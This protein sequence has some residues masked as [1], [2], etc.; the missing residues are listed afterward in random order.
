MKALVSGGRMTPQPLQIQNHLDLLREALLSADNPEFLQLIR[1]KAEDILRELEQSEQDPLEGRLEDVDPAWMAQ[2]YEA[3]SR[4]E[5]FLGDDRKLIDRLFLARQN[6]EK[7]IGL[8]F[9]QALIIN[10][11][12]D[13]LSWKGIDPPRSEASAA[14]R[15]ELCESP[16]VAASPYAK[17]YLVPFGMTPLTVFY[18]TEAIG[19]LAE[20]LIR[21]GGL[22]TGQ[23]IALSA[24]NG[25]H[26]GYQQ[27]EFTMT[28]SEVGMT[29]GLPDSQSAALTKWCIRVAQFKQELF[30]W[31]SAE[32]LGEDAVGMR[33]AGET[34]ENLFQRWAKGAKPQVLTAHARS[35]A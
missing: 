7:E 6:E 24:L 14:Q 9:E 17:E 3:L 1:T 4:E 13:V 29:T 12:G 23:P 21:K 8:A 25:Q 27:L 20:R 31:F 5:E 10:L 26:A 30:P 2:V 18:A 16:S 19:G 33:W 15:S 34:T 11:P 28:R 32:P 22:K 35:W